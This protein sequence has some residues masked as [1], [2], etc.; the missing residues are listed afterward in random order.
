MQK[1][2]QKGP[3]SAESPLRAI[4]LLMLRGQKQTG[5][6]IVELLIVIVV[7][8]IL[9]AITMVAY[10][11]VTN[12]AKDSQTDSSV[13]QMKK[14]IEMYMADNGVYPAVC[15][16]GD[17]SGC[18]AELLAGALVPTY[19]NKLPEAYPTGYGVYQYVR[20]TGGTAYA[21]YLRYYSKANCK[22]GVNVNVGW[23]GSGLV[24][25]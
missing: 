15:G 9:A 8:G 17:N 20:G 6:T 1:R 24:T 13:S 12:R 4:I 22:T 11:N 3:F 14:L 10:S 2:P 7:I 25:C 23:W 19:A 18:N 16:G 5:F 21:I